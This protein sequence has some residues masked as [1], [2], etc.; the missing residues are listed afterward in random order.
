M[1]KDGKKKSTNTTV[2]EVKILIEPVVAGFGGYAMPYV[3][4]VV[5]GEDDEK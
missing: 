3:K 5:K 1:E 2:E 4:I